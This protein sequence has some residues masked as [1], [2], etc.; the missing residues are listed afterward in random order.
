MVEWGGGGGIETA[1]TDSD[2]GNETGVT[3]VGFCGV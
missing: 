1:E 2:N 3:C